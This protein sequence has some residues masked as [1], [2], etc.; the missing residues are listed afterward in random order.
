M[1]AAH[2]TALAK[3]EVGIR[4]RA[5]APAFPE[6]AERFLDWNLREHREHQTT[7]DFYEDMVRSLLRYEP[8][9]TVRIDKIDNEVRD[10]FIDYRLRCTRNYGDPAKEWQGRIPGLW[11]TDL[12]RDHQSRVGHVEV[13]VESRA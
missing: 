9:K 6:L 12:C 11:E 1:E 10:S 5:K 8:F 2:R 13:H 4:E 7:I 3:G